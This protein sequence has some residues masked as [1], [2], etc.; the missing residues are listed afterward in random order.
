MV[1]SYM[2]SIRLKTIYSKE[3]IRSS[4]QKA[5]KRL[6]NLNM[7]HEG[8]FFIKCLHYEQQKKYSKQMKAHALFL[9][10][11]VVSSQKKNANKKRKWPNNYFKQKK[12]K[13]CKQI[14]VNGKRLLKWDFLHL[15]NM[16]LVW[17][18]KCVSV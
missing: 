4:K 2:F 11:T 17:S 3:I 12:Y 10:L 7:T 9:V 14:K 8:F 18:F 13:K 16:M 5:Q 15:K 1:N 6:F